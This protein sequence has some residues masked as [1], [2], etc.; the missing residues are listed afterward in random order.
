MTAASRASFQ[1]DEARNYEAKRVDGTPWRLEDRAIS[2]L[3]H[4][5]SGRVLDLPCG[6]GRWL[7]LYD[8]LG[9]ECVGADVSADMLAEARV[10]GARAELVQASA[11]D[12]LPFEPGAF[13][14]LVCSRFF[15][16][17][18]LSEVTHLL[19]NF[20]RVLKP[21]GALLVT[22]RT[23]KTVGG[24]FFT[25]DLFERAFSAAGY[26]LATSCLLTPTH[27]AFLKLT[28]KA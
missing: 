24:D 12:P 21:G 20:R 25:W 11:F 7:K 17:C 22:V 3:L 27:R 2:R 13:D 18:D 28:A 4:G 8:R 6:T 23:F 26:S 10:K 14:V 5:C 15:E 16:H 19:G 9:F 1:G